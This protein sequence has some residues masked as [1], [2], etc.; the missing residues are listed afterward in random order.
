MNTKRFKK[1]R[2]IKDIELEKAN[3]RYEMLV[4]ENK[5]MDNFES[6]AT[7]FS[8]S[9]IIVRANKSLNTVLR[10]YSMISNIFGHKKKIDK[11]EGLEK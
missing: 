11:K 8:I 2:T 5:M 3:L 1:I 6:L 9:S 10:T 7:V 4:A